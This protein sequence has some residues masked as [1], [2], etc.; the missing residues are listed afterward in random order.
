MGLFDKFKK[1]NDDNAVPT[2]P[3]SE[4][5][6]A[7]EGV[8]MP[9]TSEAGNQAMAVAV[10]PDSNPFVE[11]TSNPVPT[12]TA[13]AAP[14]VPTLDN[15]FNAEPGDLIMPESPA[16]QEEPVVDMQIQNVEVNEAGEVVA[17]QVVS[18]TETAAV[19]DNPIPGAEQQTMLNVNPEEMING[20]TKEDVITQMVSDNV[21]ATE[22]QLDEVTE[23]YGTEASESEVV[24]ETPQVEEPQVEEIQVAETQV[25]ENP[26]VSVPEE[27]EQPVGQTEV[28]AEQPVVENIVEEAPEALE[29]EQLVEEPQ[30]MEQVEP[31]TI[32][33]EQ[34]AEQEPVTEPSADVQ[35]QPVETPQ[36]AENPDVASENPPQPEEPGKETVV[37]SEEI[38]DIV[39]TETI[40]PAEIVESQNNPIELTPTVTPVEEPVQVL[41]LSNDDNM[42]IQTNDAPTVDNGGATLENETPESPVVEPVNE[43]PALEQVTLAPS[44][45]EDVYN[46]PTEEPKPEETEEVEKPEVTPVIENNI[47]EP[48]IEE[49]VE[50]TI[51]N[52]Q[53]EV[54]NQDSIKEPTAEETATEESSPVELNVES[55]TTNEEPQTK[56][57]PSSNEEES[58]VITEEPNPEI[59]V[60]EEK[61]EEI[62]EQV[63]EP[64]PIIEEESS[65]LNVQNSDAAEE[66]VEK[67]IIEEEKEEL[68]LGSSEEQT[69]PFKAEEVTE[70]EPNPEIPIVEEEKE[71]QVSPEESEEQIE[72]TSEEEQIPIISETEEQPAEEAEVQNPIQDISFPTINSPTI[73]TTP[74]EMI[75]NGPTIVEAEEEG[76]YISEPTPTKFCNNCGVMLTDDSSICPSCGE[77]ID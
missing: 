24:A 13:E 45:P 64:K 7:N 1:K 67:P 69:A 66:P 68:N 27:V 19:I 16:V 32:E 56:E 17:E 76:T 46:T 50:N 14:E 29:T 8:T 10:G 36:V 34:V 75:N 73:E 18:P 48:S 23:T 12:E 4:P 11:T 20:E 3:Q 25:A 52:E 71:E 37:E 21:A 58:P 2:P 39:P 31:S 47:V 35:D 22:Q 62:T 9:E 59:P 5:V 60:V 65:E 44:T 55:P 53:P 40:L 77:P 6:I 28:P 51:E 33:T 70:E 74:N 43:E 41:E 72:I 38:E 63:A 61:T 57:E 15:M 30:V 42:A 49:S 26:N 54:E